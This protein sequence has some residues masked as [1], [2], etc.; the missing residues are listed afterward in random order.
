MLKA[1]LFVLYAVKIH[2]LLL[3]GPTVATGTMVCRV[4]EG[5]MSLLKLLSRGPALL[6]S[7]EFQKTSV[8]E[9]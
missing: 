4:L 9:S 3:E 6:Y 7:D 1:V 2:I 5:L 8:F